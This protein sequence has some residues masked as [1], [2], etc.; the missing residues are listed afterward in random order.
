VADEELDPARPD[1]IA[2]AA[3][4]VADLFAQRQREHVEEAQKYGYSSEVLRL[5]AGN[6]RGRP[7]APSYGTAENAV[8]K[9]SLFA[10]AREAEAQRA[11]YNVS[12]DA[13]VLGTS[14]AANVTVALTTDVGFGSNPITFPVRTPKPPPD[15]DENRAAT[16]AARLDALQ[17][18]L[19][20]TFRAAR[21][22]VL[23]VTEDSPRIALSEMRQ[24]YDVLM[25]TLAPDAEVRASPFFTKKGGEKPD[26]VHRPER[27]RYA[28]AK[29]IRDTMRRILMESEVDNIVRVYEDLNRLH[30][31]RPVKQDVAE[32]VVL[33][34]R[35]IIESWLDAVAP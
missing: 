24:T 20:N 23:G 13:Y 35:S 32:P 12:S 29:H 15:W 3:E 18:G 31:D 16:Y 9:F 4:E 30:S 34:M 11:R 1:R 27:I 17:P 26:Q 22:H 14:I 19:G 33:A 6:F 8:N 2:K 5:I 21:S 7:D 25:R 28:A 10:K